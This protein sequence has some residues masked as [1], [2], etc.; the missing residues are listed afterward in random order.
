[1]TV[2]IPDGK[3]RAAKIAFAV[4]CG[5][6]GVVV[7]AIVV[8]A[9]NRP[10]GEPT[11]QGR[12]EP[13]EPT[14][15]AT[16]PAPVATPTPSV[17][18]SG[19]AGDGNSP[20]AVVRAPRIAFRV[21]ATVYVA[22]EDGTPSKKVVS[23][24]AIGAYSLSPNGMTLAVVN[25]PNLELVDVGSGKRTA[26]GPAEVSPP[27]W[28]PDSDGALFVKAVGG[29]KFEVWRV[30]ADG[31]SPRRIAAGSAVSVSPD[32]RVV[33]VRPPDG[34]FAPGK[35]AGHV[36]VSENGGSFKTVSVTGF[37]TAVAAGNNRMFI[38]VDGPSGAGIVSTDLGGRAARSLRGAPSGD[39]ESTW[40]GLSLSPDGTRVV[41]AATGDDGYSRI[42]V[43]PASGGSEVRLSQRRDGYVRG[44][45]AKGDAIFM[46]EGNYFQGEPTVLVSVRPDGSRRTPVVTGAEP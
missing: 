3:A 46:I 45:N 6:L 27:V 10:A 41:A 33:V 17:E 43:L 39:A 24:S 14:A 23:G 15:E 20:A 42:S 9:T 5:L 32:G 37:P 16:L 1:M 8:W 40:T 28:E 35:T 2:E 31:G 7:I 4:A 44:W 21:G 30:E 12:I 38:A 26:V 22:D 36:L 25:G 11:K 34:G 29:S 13:A 18:G 19:G